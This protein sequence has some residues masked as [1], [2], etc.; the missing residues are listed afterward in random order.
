MD[1]SIEEAHE[2]FKA[3]LQDFLP[4]QK[5]NFNRQEI[6]KFLSRIS[7]WMNANIKKPAQCIVDC[8][9]LL[10]SY[11]VYFFNR[12]TSERTIA[13]WKRCEHVAAT[14]HNILST[15]LFSGARA[16]RDADKF[17]MNLNGKVSSVNG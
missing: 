7:Q 6:L 9:N 16:K 4:K 15:D 14:L 3:I 12:G 5:E 2:E 8:E 13:G 1:S 17:K 10:S 11:M